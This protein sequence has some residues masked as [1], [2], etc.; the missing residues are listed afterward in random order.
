MKKLLGFALCF[1]LIAGAILAQSI[2]V[3][4]PNGNENWELGKTQNITWTYLNIPQN[5]KVKLALWKD[6]SKIGDIVTDLP[7]G[8]SGS[9]SYPW[10]VGSYQGGTAVAG[11]GYKVRIR[12]MQNQYETDQS[13]QLFTIAP[14]SQAPGQP[15]T[16]GGPKAHV[17]QVAEAMIAISIKEPTKMSVWTIGETHTIRWSAAD[18]VKYP[19]WLF[20]VSADH[21]IP[22]VDIGKVQATGQTRP[23]EKTWTVTDNLYDGQYCIRITS[24]DRA[25]EQHSVPFT[26]KASKTT[27]YEVLP[28]A[29]YNKVQWHNF[30]GGDIWPG[31]VFA[32]GTSSIPDPGGKIIKYGYQRWYDEADTNGYTLHHSY[33]FFDLA[34]VISKLIGPATVKS[35]SIHWEKAAN[36]PQACF[37]V[38]WALDGAMAVGNGSNMF[39][40]A[41]DAF[42][43]H[44]VNGSSQLQM[45]IAQRWLT[46]PAKN[47]G[48]VICSSV[49]GVVG[50]NTQCVEFG[51]QV[52]LKL[53]IEEKL[54]K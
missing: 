53:T 40:T 49:E 33:V 32:G 51:D 24:A 36:S 48:V 19:L 44:K 15:S 10:S 20:L 38:I 6:G 34:G 27:T 18:R 13:N 16:P 1:L 37:S 52:V 14:A 7:I 42:P 4:S 28:S 12:D 54:N 5:K 11:T 8:I 26:I 22:I 43:K 25:Y 35:A 39:G 47:Y 17:G 21:T 23:M 29:V 46:D 2:T 41:F 45:Q 31:E 3:T 9:G 30:V 50:Q